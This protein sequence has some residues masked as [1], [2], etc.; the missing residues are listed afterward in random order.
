MWGG[1]EYVPIAKKKENAQ[2][3]LAKLKKKNPDIRPVVITGNKI[4]KTWWGA[5]WNKNLE[6]YADYRNRIERGRAYVKNGF[7]LDLRID[8]ESVTAIVAGSGR[9]PYDVEINI[10]ALPKDKWERITELCGR[11]IA[12]IDELVQGKFP[13][14]LETLFTQKGEGLFPS[15]K[16]IKFS[17]S[18]PDY[19]YMCKHVA[20]VLYAVGA[21]LDEEPSLFFKLRSIEIEALIKRS[22]EE[23]MENMLKNSE[24]KTRRVIADADIGDLFGI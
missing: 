1:Y 7:V 18:C 2:K 15:P 4:G 13:K 8:A 22:I 19:A 23:K 6:S 5:A 3:A 20:A 24:R 16:E 21:R 12:N 10:A 11:S 9:N 14:E 17:C